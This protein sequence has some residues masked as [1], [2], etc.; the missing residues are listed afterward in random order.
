MAF[1]LHV[2]AHLPHPLHRQH[3]Q[4][5]QHLQA[6]VESQK[7]KTCPIGFMSHPGNNLLFPV[8]MQIPAL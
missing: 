3:R 1:N 2:E 4:H 7:R 8:Q 5:L 6:A